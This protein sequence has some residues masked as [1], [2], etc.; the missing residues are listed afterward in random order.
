LVLKAKI[1]VLGLGLGPGTQ[2]LGLGL[3]TQV[4]G[5]G[6]GE[7]LKKI[8]TYYIDTINSLSFDIDTKL[9][10]ICGHIEFVP[11]GYLFERIIYFLFL[12]AQPLFKGL[13]RGSFSRVA[14]RPLTSCENVDQNARVIGVCEVFHL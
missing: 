4:L 8:L 3:A 13:L 1:Q 2:V 7:R 9:A 12:P 5:L 14:Y 6:L 10:D 11:L